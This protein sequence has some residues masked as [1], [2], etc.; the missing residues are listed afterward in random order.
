MFGKS[1]IKRGSGARLHVNRLV[2]LFAL[3]Y[4]LLRPP[5]ALLRLKAASFVMANTSS[6]SG[7]EA[8]RMSECITWAPSKRCLSTKN[9]SW[10]NMVKYIVAWKLS[11]HKYYLKVSALSDALLL[12]KSGL[13]APNADHPSLRLSVISVCSRS[14]L[15]A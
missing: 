7:V 10:S 1:L 13:H 2:A 6:F 3:R 5:F 15:L 14:V 11:G 9:M 4:C 8:E 12:V